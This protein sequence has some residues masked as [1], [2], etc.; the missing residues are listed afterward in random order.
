MLRYALKHDGVRR[1]L[2]SDEETS[3]AD[4]A[5]L[6]LAGHRAINTPAARG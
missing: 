4:R 2:A 6:L 5:L 1:H 3:A